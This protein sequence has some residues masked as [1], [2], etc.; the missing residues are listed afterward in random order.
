MM[1]SA[2]V[3]GADDPVGLRSGIRPGLV[4]QR[5]DAE[6]NPDVHPG[7]LGGLDQPKNLPALQGR[8]PPRGLNGEAACRLGWGIGGGCPCGPRCLAWIDGYLH[9]GVG[10]YTFTRTMT[11]GQRQAQQSGAEGGPVRPRRAVAE[12][13]AIDG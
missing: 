10:C 3:G 12:P 4:E 5:R 2:G 7:P 11:T 6:G 13:A 8:D 1:A 9:L